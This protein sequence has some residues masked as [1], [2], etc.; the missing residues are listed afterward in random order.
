MDLAPITFSPSVHISDV[1]SILTTLGALFAVHRANQKR[2]AIMDAK[3]GL[4]FEWFRH[5]VI[6]G[7]PPAGRTAQGGRQ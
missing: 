6:N 5:H 1:V 3:I 4:M 2:L 7:A